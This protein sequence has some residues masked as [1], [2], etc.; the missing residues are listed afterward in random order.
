MPIDHFHIRSDLMPGIEPDIP[1]FLCQIKIGRNDGF[2]IYD[3][4]RNEGL[5]E[6]EPKDVRFHLMSSETFWIEVH[7]DDLPS[8]IWGRFKNF[9]QFVNFHRLVNRDPKCSVIIENLLVRLS[10]SLRL[11]KRF[12]TFYS[13]R[14]TEFC[15]QKVVYARLMRKMSMLKC[16][17][18][19][20]RC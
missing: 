12:D 5:L 6:F 20:P 1:V 14:N 13:R 2:R 7:P 3:H 16:C 9:Y 15:A 18:R 19:D 17:T 10:G 8:V 11:L 4:N